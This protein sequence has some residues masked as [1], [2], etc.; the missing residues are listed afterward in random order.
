MDTNLVA[1]NP[2]AL[3]AVSGMFASD[4]NTTAGVRMLSTA[5]CKFTIKDGSEE[6]ISLGDEFDGIIAAED[7]ADHFIYYKSKYDPSAVTAP[8][9][10]WYRNTKA[11]ACVPESALVRDADGRL[12]Y[13]VKRRIVVFP[14]YKGKLMPDPVAFDVSGQSLYKNADK[15]SKVMSYTQYRR[16][17]VG[18]HA[19]PIQVVTHFSFDPKATVS[20]VRFSGVRGSSM[21]EM[22]GILAQKEEVAEL[23]KVTLKDGTESSG[24][25]G[26][27]GYQP[28]GFKIN[29]LPAPNSVPADPE[30]VSATPATPASSSASTTA[31]ASMES[32]TEPDM[33]AAGELD[34]VLGDI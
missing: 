13:Q 3:A 26:Q 4:L 22:N 27:Q 32:I 18:V 24:S 9:A 7:S 6:G 16:F 20:V 29:P 23:A 1:L 2:E 5:R 34:S 30:P 33:D 17:L 28:D 12:G 19:L 10:V 15:G 14:F 8:D 25:A 31:P 21:Q 11:P